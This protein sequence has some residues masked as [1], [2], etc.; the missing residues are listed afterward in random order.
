MTL[1][2]NC[3]HRYASGFELH[4]ATVFSMGTMLTAVGRVTADDVVDMRVAALVGRAHG[5]EHVLGTEHAVVGRWHDVGPVR[6][7]VGQVQ[8]PGP[9]AGGQLADVRR[10]RP[11]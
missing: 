2:F 3:E 9:V 4:E 11:F 10:R 1:N 6:L 5:R 7:D 8:A